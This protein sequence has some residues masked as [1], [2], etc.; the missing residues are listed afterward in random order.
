M[1]MSLFSLGGGR[2]ADTH[3]PLK[4]MLAICRLYGNQDEVNFEA[5]EIRDAPIID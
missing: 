1:F 4:A 3:L 5:L 2:G